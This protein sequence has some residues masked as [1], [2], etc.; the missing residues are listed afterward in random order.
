MTTDN[1][2]VQQ[3]QLVTAPSAPIGNVPIAHGERPEKFTGLN[4]KRW[5]QKMLFYLTTLNLARFLTEEPPKHVEDATVVEAWNHSEFLCRNYILNGLADSL[6]AVYSM[7]RTAKELWES[8][9]KKYKTEDAGAKKFIVGRFLDYKMVDSKTVI[10]QV[11]ELQVILHEIHS[12]DMVLSETFQPTWSST[13]KARNGRILSLPKLDPEE[14]Y[15]RRKFSGKCFNCDRVGHKS[16]ECRKPKKKQEANLNE[17]LEVDDLCAVI[18]ELNLVCSNPRQWWMDTGATRHVCCNKE[19]LHNFEEVKGEK[20][21]M[22]NSATSD[23]MGQGKVVLKMT[24]GKELT[25]NNVLYV[26]EVRKNLVSGSLLSKHGFRI[27]CESDRVVLSK[28]GVHETTA[29]YTP[30]QNGVAERKNRTL[31]EMMNALLLS[32]G[33]PEYMWGEAVLT[34]N[35]LLNKVPRKKIEKSPYELWKGR[36]PSYKYLRVWGCLAKVMVPDPKRIKIGPKTVDCIFIGYAHNSCAYRFL[37]YE[38]QVPEIHKNSIIESRNASFFEHVFPYKTR[39]EESSSKRIYE[40]Q[41][42]EEV[43]EPI[44]VEP[45]RSKRARVEKSFGTDFITFMLESDPQT[46]SEA[47]NSSEGPQWKEA[48]ASEIDSILQNHTWELVDLPPGSKPLGCKW[49]FK[50]KIKSDGTIDKY[51]ARLSIV[52]YCR[53]MESGNTSNGCKDRLSKR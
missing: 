53:S 34:A 50:K 23:V 31:K 32:S 33:L 10:S 52:G 1:V 28:N 17:G 16:S 15:P 14:A 2:E 11:Q 29:P 35:Y 22:G 21:Y 37:V 24:S 36:Q 25:L 41:E 13:V 40:S 9:D 8:L 3:T 38:S 39:E 44:E 12:E 51:K 48:I 4:F 20:L 26:P 49:I 5:Q 43:D 47:V 30:Q 46:Y 18:T 7:K 42:E 27:V 19:L 45:R 6:Y